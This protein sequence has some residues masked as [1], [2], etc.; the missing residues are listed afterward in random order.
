METATIKVPEMSNIRQWMRDNYGKPRYVIDLECPVKSAYIIPGLR[1]QVNVQDQKSF[2]EL[3]EKEACNQYHVPYEEFRENY[4]SRKRNFSDI[5]QVV[6]YFT[7]KYFPQTTFKHL[8]GIYRKHH[9]TSI[10]GIQ[11]VQNLM[12][13][14]KA[15]KT[16]IF[17]IESKLIFK[18]L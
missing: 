12:E 1:T 17:G 9:S 14:D 6:W 8:A 15:F 13:T 10:W 5:R 11:N 18:P 7:K 4:K 2:I 3:I 16:E